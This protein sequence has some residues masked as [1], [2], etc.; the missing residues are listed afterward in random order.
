[1]NFINLIKFFP[2]NEALGAPA[3]EDWSRLEQSGTASGAGSGAGSGTELRSGVAERVSDGRS[4]KKGLRSHAGAPVQGQDPKEQ[5]AV[6]N[7]ATYRR[8]LGWHA[9]AD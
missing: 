1:M 7:G 8:E 2:N 5:G 4:L 6:C 9:R 3:L